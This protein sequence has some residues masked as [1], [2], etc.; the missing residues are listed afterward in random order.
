MSYKR[1]SPQ[2]VVEGGTGAQTLTGILVGT[3]TTAVTASTVTQYDVLVGGASNAVSSVA[4]TSTAGIPLVSGGSGANP[5][6]TTAVVAGGGTGLSSVT[7]YAPVVGGATSTANLSQV[8]T[9]LNT[10]GYVLT[11]NGSGAPTFQAVPSSNV[12]GITSVNFLASPYTVL[13]T[14]NFLAVDS[15]SGAIT[16]NLPNAPTTGRVYYIKDSTGTATGANSMTITTVGGAVDIDGATSQTI[17]TAY[18][19][20]N[21]IFD[22][23]GYE[24]W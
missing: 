13:S 8:T 10:A 19:S 16:I 6:F 24:I 21:V 20:M 17:N 4:P 14:D 22:G 3:G 7:A 23:V 5:S 15:T 9:G 1:K 12:I 11:A 2:P 18:Q